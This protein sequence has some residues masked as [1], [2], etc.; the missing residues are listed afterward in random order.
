VASGADGVGT[1]ITKQQRLEE[2]FRRLANAAPESSFEGAYQL[3]CKTIDQVEDELSGL[4]NEPDRWMELG[5]L[6]PP[7]TDRMSSVEGCDV[8]RFDS[9]RHVTYIATNGAME[10]RLIRDPVALFSKL[11]SDGRGVCD[12]CPELASNNL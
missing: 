12:V 1:A 5:R 3:L 11:A 6:S 2:V 9:R 4:P 10:I 8:K 7:Q